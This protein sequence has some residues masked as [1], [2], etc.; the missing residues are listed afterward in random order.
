MTVYAG[1][2]VHMLANGLPSVVIKD[3]QQLETANQSKNLNMCLDT[4]YF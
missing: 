4:T 1:L 3:C 2:P